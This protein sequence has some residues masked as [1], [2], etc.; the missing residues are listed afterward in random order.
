M[1]DIFQQAYSNEF[2]I[3]FYEIHNKKSGEKNIPPNINLSFG[4]NDGISINFE[5]VIINGLIYLVGD[6]TA[7][8]CSCF[9]STIH[10]KLWL[11]II[12]IPKTDRSLKISN[13]ENHQLF[14]MIEFVATYQENIS[15]HRIL[16]YLNSYKKTYETL[17]NY[18]DYYLRRII[19]CNTDLTLVD[20]YI[21]LKDFLLLN[22]LERTI[23]NIVEKDSFGDN[24][25]YSLIFDSLS[26]NLYIEYIS[27]KKISVKLNLSESSVQLLNSNSVKEK[28]NSFSYDEIRNF[29]EIDYIEN[30]LQWNNGSDLLYNVLGINNYKRYMSHSGSTIGI[31]EYYMEIFGKYGLTE[32]LLKNYYKKL[33]QNIRTLENDLRYIE[34]YNIVG[35]LYNETLLYNLIK[36]A[37][38]DC[39]V[40]SQYSPSWL[41]R[42]RIDIYIQELNVGVEYNGLQ[43]YQAVEYFGGEM[44]FE[45]TQKRDSLKR[46]LCSENDL[47][48]LEV[49]Y[50]EDINDFIE[51]LR[52][53][54]FNK[55]EYSK[56]PNI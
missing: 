28:F 23:G 46:K 25:L 20:K 1:R 6:K 51:N 41:K 55:A 43:H 24:E 34:G 42:Q 19:K 53:I 50:N 45:E 27:S 54:Y 49:K 2:D 18:S 26:K 12:A 10:D 4:F 39:R 40:I 13:S 29:L 36:S 9:F 56:S 14:L 37:F 16:N 30:E 5:I 15:S 48:L 11:Q 8:A 21:L 52:R 31:V 47:T 22:P 33:K 17:G 44:G 38:P 35:S 7:Y 32:A 3:D